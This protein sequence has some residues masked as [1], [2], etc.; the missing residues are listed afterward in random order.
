[1]I[2]ARLC[3]DLLDGGTF[4]YVWAA[5]SV[6]A[7]L[8]LGYRAALLGRNPVRPRHWLGPLFG[9]TVGPALWLWVADS[10]RGDCSRAEG[11]V[12]LAMPFCALGCVVTL[13]GYTYFALRRR[14]MT[15]APWLELDAPD[16]ERRL[17]RATP[18]QLRAVAWGACDLVRSRHD[19]GA[20]SE[21]GRAGLERLVQR[22]D[23]DAWD[24]EDAGDEEAYA[25]RF[26]RARAANTLLAARDPDPM[27]AA[28][29]ALYEAH[30]ATE[31]PAA[32]RAVAER[33]LG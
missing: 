6:V 19:L 23:E 21:E 30:A 29:E 16:L 1:V 4:T 20:A 5:I 12:L 28:T 8:Y 10:E 18:E 2:A 15:R 13:V 26:M 14:R 9:I 7:G 33:A 31:D 3:S 25:A 27:K 11:G 17:R 32:V 22:L 24:A